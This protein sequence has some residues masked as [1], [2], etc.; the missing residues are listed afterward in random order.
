[1]P[2]FYSS[3]YII[4]VLRRKGF[5][6]VSQKGSH[7]KFQK[8]SLPLTVIVPANRKEIPIGTF[9]SILRQSKLKDEDFK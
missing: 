5:V 2:K 3:D 6:F 8:A 1:M 9:R 7:M 4:K